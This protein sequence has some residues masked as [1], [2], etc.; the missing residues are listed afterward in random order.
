M[1][2]ANGQSVSASDLN[3]AF[4]DG[5]YTSLETER[6]RIPGATLH[7]VSFFEVLSGTNANL[8]TMTFTPNDDWELI[9][10]GC[11][12]YSSTSAGTVT[13]TLTG[14]G[15]LDGGSIALTGTHSAASLDLT[16]YYTDTSKPFQVL[17]KGADYTWTVSTDQASGNTLIQP[18]VLYRSRLRRIA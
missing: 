5:Y 13:A 11:Y 12:S 8:R 3:S 6:Q 10:V 17:L 14:T 18:F 16:R 1:T 9:E 2:I 4:A 15:L 7:S